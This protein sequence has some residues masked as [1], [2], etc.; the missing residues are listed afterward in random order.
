VPPRLNC[1]SS[2]ANLAGYLGIGYPCFRPSALTV[3]LLATDEPPISA[4]DTYKNPLWSTI[5]PVYLNRKAKFVG[6][7]GSGVAGTSVDTDMQ[8][9]AQQTGSV[10]AANGNRPLVFNG[11]D[12]NSATAIENGIRTLAN[13]LPLD[14]SALAV[15][16]PADAVDAISAFVDHLQTLQLGT[17]ACA[18]GLNETDSNGDGFAD[19]YLQVRT[20]TPVCWK[21]VSKQ[22]TTVPATDAPQLFR[23]TV[24]V[25]GD[26]VT[27]LDQRNVFFLVPPQPADDPIF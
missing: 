8:L 25:Y 26:G 11:A 2:P 20:G 22:N 5:L 1:N 19:K 15:D 27:Q 7:L 23:A 12:A 4:G 21:V 14:I 3:I 13:G 6:I 17:A 16:D 18:A 9:M 10:D 24:R